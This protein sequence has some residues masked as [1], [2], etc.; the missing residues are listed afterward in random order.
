VPRRHHRVGTQRVRIGL[1]AVELGPKRPQASGDRSLAGALLVLALLGAGREIDARRVEADESTCELD[2]VVAALVDA[3]S[4][5]SP[6]P[7]GR[8]NPRA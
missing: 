1:P 8:L 2:E 7:T 3:R 4:P 6:I 5:A